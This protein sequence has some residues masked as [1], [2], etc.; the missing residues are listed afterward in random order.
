MREG[1]RAAHAVACGTRGTS[2]P[3]LAT[4]RSNCP[5]RPTGCENL[6][7]FRAGTAVPA[8][9][10]NV[11]R[12]RRFTSEDFKRRSTV[13]EPPFDVF[14]LQ[15]VCL[16]G[17]RR[18]K[19]TKSKAA[20][21]VRRRVRITMPSRARRRTFRTSRQHVVGPRLRC[22]RRRRAS[23]PDHRPPWAACLRRRGWRRG[24]GAARAVRLEARSF[25]LSGLG[26]PCCRD[27]EASADVAY[28]L[29]LQA[30]V[31]ARSAAAAI[32]GCQPS[33][34]VINA[35]RVTTLY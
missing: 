7:R 6:A 31:R 28:L 33:G 11:V 16:A 9:A 35:P 23:G 25:C 34:K 27:D 10:G 32:S 13:L 14:R 17:I 29:P 15:S 21:R 5:P 1:A 24:G 3:K 26:R 22:R 30:A 12:S 19:T 18:S 4:P 2:L 8:R 20:R